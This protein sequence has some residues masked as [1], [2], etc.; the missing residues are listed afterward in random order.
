MPKDC[1]HDPHLWPGRLTAVMIRG[2]TELRLRV[3]E[4]MSCVCIEIDGTPYPVLLGVT[5]TGAENLRTTI[6]TGLADLAA[7]RQASAGDKTAT[8]TDGH[9]EMGTRIPDRCVSAS[10][11]AHEPD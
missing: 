4:K 6:T 11:D 8:R 9:V 10:H 5:A 3:D 1:E 2:A 7:R